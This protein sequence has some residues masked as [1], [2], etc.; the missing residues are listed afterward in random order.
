MFKFR[1]LIGVSRG[2]KKGPL[3]NDGILSYFARST[4]TNR[5][6]GGAISGGIEEAL[7]E[8]AFVK[9]L[10]LDEQQWEEFYTD[11][12]KATISLANERRTGQ[13]TVIEEYMIPAAIDYCKDKKGNFNPRDFEA[14]VQDKIGDDKY[15]AVD[16][17]IPE[18]ADELYEA[19]EAIFGIGGYAAAFGIGAYAG[20]FGRGIRG[21]GAISYKIGRTA[22]VRKFH[23]YLKT[24]SRLNSIFSDMPTPNRAFGSNRMAL[25]AWQAGGITK[26]ANATERSYSEAALLYGGKEYRAYNH[27]KNI[28]KLNARGVYLPSQ[29]TGKE[30]KA[31]LAAIQQTRNQVTNFGYRW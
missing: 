5:G 14:Y 2:L 29:L 8:F 13:R 17:I 7:E 23:D 3:R 16:E 20:S 26:F 9:S 28:K 31:S 4:K 15:N 22:A 6:G 12:L 27:R 25:A 30:R 21:S 18:V 11:I 10:N 1:R 19:N 24:S